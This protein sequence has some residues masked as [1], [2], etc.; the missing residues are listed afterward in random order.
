MT[1]E[2]RILA[3]E[4]IYLPDEGLYPIPVLAQVGK[5]PGCELLSVMLAPAA[6]VM[7]AICNDPNFKIE[8]VMFDACLN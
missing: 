2:V 6:L 3:C 4:H 5:L 1:G 8:D 7:D